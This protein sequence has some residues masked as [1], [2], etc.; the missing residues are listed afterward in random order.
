M[1]NTTSKTTINSTVSFMRVEKICYMLAELTEF[2]AR[3]FAMFPC[4]FCQQ[5][6]NHPRYITRAPDRTRLACKG[7]YE[8]ILAGKVE[9][10]E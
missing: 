4:E 2:Q 1:S 6:N 8:N 7:C 5:I 10:H 3:V 9:C